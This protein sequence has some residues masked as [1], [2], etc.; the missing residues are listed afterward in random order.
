MDDVLA[1]DVS[2]PVLGK[3][4]ALS[5]LPATPVDETNRFGSDA[6]AAAFGKALFFDERLSANGQVSCA[7]CHDPDR[8]FT[9]GRQLAVGLDVGNRHTP[10][11]WNVAHHR[12][13]TWDGRADSLWMQALDPLEDPREMGTNRGRVALVIADDA[14]LRAQYEAT[15]GALP[16]EATSWG[17]TAAREIGARPARSGEA[18]SGEL[19][20]VAQH[21]NSLAENEQEALG[22]VFV[23]AG[24]AIAAFQTT[25]VRGDSPFDTF[26]E[27][28]QEN[29]PQKVAALSPAA[30]RGLVLFI[31]KG[32]C[33]LCH[34]GPLFSDGEFHNNSLPTLSGGEPEDPGRYSGAGVVRASPFNAGGQYS[35]APDGERA[36]EV[37]M[38]STSSETWGE[39]RTPSL[40]NLAERAPFMHQ[41]QFQDLEEVINFYSEHE[42]ASGRNHHQE[43]ILVPLRLSGTEKADLLAFLLS[44]EG[45]EHPAHSPNEAP[46][47]ASK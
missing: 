13:L 28:L 23:H 20:P 34:S 4:A 16:D 12:W 15:F 22:R 36:R 11:L 24:K 42:G 3:I 41:G 47:G 8:G 40:R 46:S 35:D 33:T 37:R 29:D 45:R 30:Q 32:N 21:W 14:A 19:P 6:G 7:T 31:G 38:L 2:P 17:T 10:T 44:L 25:L 27:G 39:F 1:I 43:Q 9:D 18:S 26:V 5:P